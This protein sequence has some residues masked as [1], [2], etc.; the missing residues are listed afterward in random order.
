MADQPSSSEKDAD[1]AP[2][3]HELK[4]I[5]YYY[6]AVWKG[7]KTF[8]ARKNDRDFRV[9]DLLHLR[10]WDATKKEYTGAEL[11]RRVTFILPP[12]ACD[13]PHDLAIMAIVPEDLP[14]VAG[15]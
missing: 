8:E 11:A 4:T 5:P 7:V 9:G 12:G 1:R 10:E 13:T 3:V 15:G 14:E 6:Q 2:K